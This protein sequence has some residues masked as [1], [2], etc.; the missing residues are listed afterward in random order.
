MSW[1]PIEN[2]KNILYVFQGFIYFIIIFVTDRILF[3]PDVYIQI[4]IF[5]LLINDLKCNR[6]RKK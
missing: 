1:Y 2:A 3:F 6:K 4:F 5:S